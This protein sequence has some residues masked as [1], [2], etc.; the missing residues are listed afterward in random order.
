MREGLSEL[1]L[2]PQQFPIPF[3]S[4]NA[5]GSVE[6]AGEPDPE[7]SEMEAQAAPSK[8]KPQ[9]DSKNRRKQS[10]PLSH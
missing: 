8:R 6:K 4:R 10:V 2:A 7:S 9:A 3:E 5:S 1:I